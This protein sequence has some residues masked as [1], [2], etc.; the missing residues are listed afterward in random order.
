MRQETGTVPS[1]AQ[2]ADRL[3]IYDVL[4]AH[5]RGVDRADAE[6]LRGCYWPDAEVAYGVFDGNAHR[7]CAFLPQAIAVYALTQHCI[8]NVAIEL[9]GDAARTETYVTAYHYA[10]AADGD[11]EV[12]FFAR[13]LDRMQKRGHVWKLAHRRVVID[14]YRNVPAAAQGSPM[15]LDGFARGARVPGDPGYGHLL[16]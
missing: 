14:W 4:V 5:C 11:R 9:D 1:A 13:Y 10:E 2:V 16:R 8:G 7:F 6:I 15:A 3:A 12:I